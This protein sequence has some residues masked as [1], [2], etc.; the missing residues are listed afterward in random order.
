M[1]RHED[2]VGLEAD[3]SRPPKRPSRRVPTRHAEIISTVG[4]KAAGPM[5]TG[6]T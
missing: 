1:R 5:Q 2:L 3:P 6:A 4:K